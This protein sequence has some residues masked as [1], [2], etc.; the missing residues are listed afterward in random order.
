MSAGK[1]IRAGRNCEI[2]L[3]I[4]L[5]FVT[6]RRGKVLDKAAVARLGAL[7]DRICQDSRAQMLRHEGTSDQV[8]LH[9]SYPAK[10][11]VSS[12]VNSLKGASSRVLRNERAELDQIAVQDEGLWSPSYLAIS[13]GADPDG[14]FERARA[15]VEQLDA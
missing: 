14:A 10:V 8:R 1:H 4:I 3:E 9:I 5:V 11:A 2:Q 13:C 12:L 6:K 15:W 7:F